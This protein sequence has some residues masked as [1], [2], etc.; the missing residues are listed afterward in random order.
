[1][2]IP[3]GFI[4]K[5]VRDQYLLFPIL[6]FP[7]IRPIVVGPAYAIAGI[8]FGM[9]QQHFHRL[10]QQQMAVEPIMIKTESVDAMFPGYLALPAKGFYVT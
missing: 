1:M 10:F 3:I 8:D 7:C 6:A 9:G 4:V 2:G 5:I